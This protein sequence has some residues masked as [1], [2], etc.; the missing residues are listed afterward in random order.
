MKVT[1]GDS[2]GGRLVGGTVF[3]GGG[4]GIVWVK[5]KVTDWVIVAEAKAEAEGLI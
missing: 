5:G 2:S 4:G 3:L 1:S